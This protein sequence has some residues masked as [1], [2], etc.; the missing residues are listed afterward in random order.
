MS[1]QVEVLRPP[2]CLADVLSS[3]SK[4]WQFP[5]DKHAPGKVPLRIQQAIIEAFQLK[6]R[7][8]EELL[9]LKS[10]MHN[11][12]NY[13]NQREH[14][15]KKL[16]LQLTEKDDSQFNRGSQCLLIKLLWEVE[17]FR[18][19]AASTFSSVISLAEYEATSPS[20]DT[21]SETSD[22]DSDSDCAIL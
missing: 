17:L 1:T 19:R 14:C 5:S 18:S 9:L 20:Y 8:D 15:I 6:R 2:V 13:W 12:I 11:V 10:E 22:E 21:D 3:D 16:L 7:C 4:V